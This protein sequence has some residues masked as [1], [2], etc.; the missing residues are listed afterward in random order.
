[1]E[2]FDKQ[3]VSRNEDILFY[4]SCIRYKVR[5]KDFLLYSKYVGTVSV[6]LCEISECYLYYA[7][8]TCNATKFRNFNLFKRAIRF[9]RL[10]S[11]IRAKMIFLKK[12][13]IEAK[14]CT[15]HFRFIPIYR[16]VSS[17]IQNYHFTCCVNSVKRNKHDG[18]TN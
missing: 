3:L 12:W 16:I 18:S 15:P 2:F 11:C 6:V 1:M 4:Q 8:I 13:Q 7:A 5:L 10:H 9:V 17:R 14:N